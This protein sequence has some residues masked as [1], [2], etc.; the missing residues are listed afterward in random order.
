MVAVS[1]TTHLPPAIARVTW[2][3]SDGVL[4]C[5]WVTFGPYRLSHVFVA[6]HNIAL[7]VL[8][9]GKGDMWPS[10][11]ASMVNYVSRA[12]SAWLAFTGDATPFETQAV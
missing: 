12:A 9:V 2:V 6:Q 7:S 8:R 10:T 5:S 11:P 4:G 1:T 3:C